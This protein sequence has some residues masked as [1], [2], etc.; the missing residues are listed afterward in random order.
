MITEAEA[1]RERKEF[2]ARQVRKAKTDAMNAWS[3]IHAAGLAYDEAV[4]KIHS[5]DLQREVRDAVAAYIEAVERRCDSMS[6]IE[7]RRLEYRLNVG[8]DYH[9]ES[10]EDGGD[11]NA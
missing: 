2:Y 6:A 3:G 4:G 9:E 11:Q 5:H 8:E 1:A 10:H 7:I